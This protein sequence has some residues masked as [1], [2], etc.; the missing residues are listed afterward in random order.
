MKPLSHRLFAAVALVAASSLWAQLAP[1]PT[2]LTQTFT[3]SS[4]TAISTP[5]GSGSTPSGTNMVGNTTIGGI[6]Y[7][8]SITGTANL[9]SAASALVTPTLA[10]YTNSAAFGGDAWISFSSQ[11]STTATDVW[12]N[13]KLLRGT[14]TNP[15]IV[16]GVGSVSGSTTNTWAAGAGDL[17]ST[18]G[19]IPGISGAPATMS[20][21]PSYFLIHIDY[22]ANGADTISIWR[23]GSE[24]TWTNAPTVA[25]GWTF[26][27]D[28]AF[29]RLGVY[30]GAGSTLA[31]DDL[32][33]TVVP[34]PST[35]ALLL[36]GASLAVVGYR[37]SRRRAD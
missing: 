13:I 16:V 6:V 5:L 10:T 3:Q 25:A 14:D 29:D 31:F 24:L 37:R 9:P 18:N 28:G 12:D 27:G 17:F 36:G 19:A 8:Q 23:S 15:G 26:T 4:W 2:V 34:E 21:G 30:A 20:A 22:A 7:N 11:R 1:P 33:L 35:Y 32:T